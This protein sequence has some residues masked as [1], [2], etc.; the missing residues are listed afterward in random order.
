MIKLILNELGM[1]FLRGAGLYQTVNT[2]QMSPHK[3]T[4]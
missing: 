4:P 3:V 2:D 1:V